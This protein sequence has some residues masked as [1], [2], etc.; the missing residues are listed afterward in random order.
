MTWLMHP[1]CLN[2]LVV[3][4]N[5]LQDCGALNLHRK[6]YSHCPHVLAYTLT[7]EMSSAELNTVKVT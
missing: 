1:T 2:M 4:N 6:V 3:A 5:K 7:E